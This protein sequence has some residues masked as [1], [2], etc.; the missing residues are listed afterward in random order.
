MNLEFSDEDVMAIE[1]NESIEE[2]WKMYFDGATNALGYVLATLIIA[3]STLDSC[4]EHNFSLVPTKSGCQGLMAECMA[5]DE[6]DMDSNSNRRTLQSTQYI[7]QGALQKN[8][9]PCS[10]TEVQYCQPREEANP[11]NRCKAAATLLV[12][13]AE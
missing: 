6:F 8:I 3:F 1:V 7:S 4:G 10:R 5:N 11:Y 2:S 12:A 9:V 13:V